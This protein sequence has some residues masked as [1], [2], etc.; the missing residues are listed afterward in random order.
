MEHDV[1][2]N[3]QSYADMVNNHCVAIID[4]CSNRFGDEC[5]HRQSG[6]EEFERRILS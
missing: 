2:E 6:M 5:V 4:L 1:D 3:P